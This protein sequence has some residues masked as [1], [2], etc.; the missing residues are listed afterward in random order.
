MTERI[1]HT[2]QDPLD[3]DERFSALVTR[4]IAANRAERASRDR[5]TKGGPVVQHAEPA[6]SQS[7]DPLVA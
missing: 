5:V 1:A 2:R 6:E 7:T 4:L 3:P